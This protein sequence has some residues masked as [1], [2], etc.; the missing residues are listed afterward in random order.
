MPLTATSGHRERMRPIDAG[1]ERE[2]PAR[3]R[4]RAL[5]SRLPRGPRQARISP[6]WRGMIAQIGCVLALGTGCVNLDQ[7]TQDEPTASDTARAEQA[8][9]TEQALAT[10]ARMSKFLSLQ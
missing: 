4:A 6:I 5:P 3:Q 7:T 10:L 2:A 8:G 1:P 9:R